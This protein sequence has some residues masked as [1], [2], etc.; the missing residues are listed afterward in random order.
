MEVKYNLELAQMILRSK[1][2][3]SFILP[4]GDTKYEFKILA[5]DRLA[6]G[7]PE[8]LGRYRS[9]L[10]DI[11]IS[12]DIETGR[13]GRYE[14][15]LDLYDFIKGDFIS[16]VNNKGDLNIG[17]L[18]GVDSSCNYATVSCQANCHTNSINESELFFPIQLVRVAYD[19]EVTK[20]MEV[21]SSKGYK[22]NGDK[23]EKI[24]P[25]KKFEPFEKVLVHTGSKG[26]LI[27]FFSK[28]IDGKYYTA[29]GRSVDAEVIIPYNEETKYLL[30]Q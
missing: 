8:G 27:D 1:V 24:N 9:E 7:K 22:L 19:S 14:I 11:I 28:K 6:N 2:R 26:W 16:C 18:S 29:L 12:F 5:L 21:I 25:E 3:G 20:F 23:L 30:N 4:R 17:I 13:S 10:T 15:L